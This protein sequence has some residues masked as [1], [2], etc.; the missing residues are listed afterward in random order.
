MK[1]IKLSARR[2]LVRLLV[3]ALALTSL[4][5]IAPPPESAGANPPQETPFRPKFAN[6][7]FHNWKVTE[8]NANDKA[9]WL[10]R[11]ESSGS[12]GGEDNYEPTDLFLTQVT[13]STYDVYWYV[14]EFPRFVRHR[15]LRESLGEGVPNGKQI[16]LQRRVQV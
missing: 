10:P 1:Q 3:A 15:Y 11:W 5:V 4:V 6:N 8:S 13:G 9:F 16:Y 2:G 7:K 12:D 14:L